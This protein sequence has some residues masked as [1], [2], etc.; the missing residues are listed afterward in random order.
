MSSELP[1]EEDSRSLI[2]KEFVGPPVAARLPTPPRTKETIAE[3]NASVA[4]L[5][6]RHWRGLA[7]IVGFF[8]L[9][10]ILIFATNAMINVG[11]R[12]ITTCDFGVSNRVMTGRI[13]A[14]ILITGSSRALTHYDSR[15]I[16]KITGRQT[17]N[18]GLNGSQTD[19]QLALF[20]AYLNHNVK[21][22]LVVNNLDLFSFVTSHEIYDPAQYMPYL[23]EEAF[24]HAICRVYPD[25]WKWKYLP[26]Y[27]Y[28]V[29]DNLFKWLLGVKGFLGFQGKEDRFQGFLPRHTTWTGDFKKF[30][31]AHPEGVKFDIEPQGVRDLT[32]LVQICRQQGIAI[33]FVYS[34]EYAEMQMLERN[35]REIFARFREICNRFNVPLWDYSESPLC[36]SRTNFYNS[37]HLNAEGAEA[38]S[39]DLA[40]R[41][42]GSGLLPPTKGGT[43]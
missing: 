3:K 14:E 22:K 32:E 13:N 19:M 30:R 28:L 24:Y 17:F 20:K 4:P 31:D 10:V 6:P 35:R 11:L 7:Q 42:A 33:M 5:N 26:L 27:G 18:I 1:N 21:P 23:K 8:G 16:Q 36:Q 37:Q 38:F 41:L 34:P 15:V 9:I 40:L 29:E 39:T 25:A 2:R 43:K 12:H